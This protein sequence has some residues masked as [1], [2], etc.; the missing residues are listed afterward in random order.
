MAHFPSR[1][2]KLSLIAAFSLLANT[3]FYALLMGRSLWLDEAIS[4]WAASGTL[5]DLYSR[6]MEYQGQSPLFFI[7]VRAAVGL[8]GPSEFALRLPS[9]VFAVLTIFFVYLEGRRA[10]DRETGLTAVIILLGL[11]ETTVAATN[12]RPYSMGLAMAVM[13]VYFLESWDLTGRAR[14]GLLYVVSALL[15]VYSHYLFAGI[16][17]LHGCY[18]LL[19]Y[20]RG[21]FLGPSSLLLGGALVC[22]GL[23]PAV[24]QLQHLAEKKLLLEFGDP[25]GIQSGLAVL[26]PAASVFLLA[27]ALLIAVI[28]RRRSFKLSPL[29]AAVPIF[30]FFLVWA[31]LPGLLLIAASNLTGVSYLVPRYAA[32][33]AP[34]L[35]LACAVLLQKFRAAGVR[36][37]ALALFVFFSLLGESTKY[38]H[39]EDWRGFAARANELLAGNE[40]TVLAY[41]G[42]IESKSTAWLEAPEHRD[43]LLAPFARYPLVSAP[44]PVPGSC[45][46]AGQQQYFA[47][48]LA[49]KPEK[50]LLL[51]R[52]TFVDAPGR[53]AVFASEALQRCLQEMGYRVQQQE[54]HE[55]TG[56][57]TFV[58]EY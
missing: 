46:N 55:D 44:T 45:A 42:L 7:L 54:Q 57:S 41:T 23:L 30:A 17:V 53:S 38:R 13:S 1:Y 9:L 36:D 6:I 12:A 20:R 25:P 16:F 14:D 28:A 19:P 29:P 39:D 11:G 27:C 58:R 5:K 22:I 35:A 40:Y 33:A 4:Y 52:E 3:V 34:G 26:L 21:R 32:W 56:L 43:Y 15:T 8:F 51:Y 24:F 49:S 50:I 10:A 18:L 2:S 47:R 48:I 31:L 37:L